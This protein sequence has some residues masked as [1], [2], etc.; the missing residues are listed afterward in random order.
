MTNKEM[1]ERS[2]KGLEEFKKLP[3]A[4]QLKRLMA[5]GTINE[6]GEVLMGS[7]D[8]NDAPAKTDVTGKDPAN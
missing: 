1:A 8:R 5:S 6:R 7:E 4:E 3:P 2:R